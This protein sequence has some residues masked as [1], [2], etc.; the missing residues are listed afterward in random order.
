MPVST[1]LKKL[2]QATLD[3]NL[4]K[5]TGYFTYRHVKH[6]KILHAYYIAFMCVV[7][8]SEQTVT[9]PFYTIKRYDF[10]SEVDSVYCA[11]RVHI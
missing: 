7:W 11:V 10:I 2:I 4:L 3:F 5:P 8:L 6:P 1:L 9:F